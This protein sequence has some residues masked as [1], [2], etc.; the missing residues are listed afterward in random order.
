MSAERTPDIAAGRL[1]AGRHCREF[2]RPPPAA[3]AHRPSSRPTAA[4]S[5]TTRP[6]SRPARPAID[7]PL[8]IREIL[9]DNPKGAAETILSAEHPRRHVR[10]RLPDRDALR[11]GLRARSGRG[12]AG[13]DRRTAALRHRRLMRTASSRSARGARP[14]SAS[15]WSAAAR[16][17]SSCAHRLAMHGHE[18]VIYEARR[19][20]RRPQRIRH[21][22]LQDGRRLR[23]GRGRF[24]ALD[25]RHHA[26]RPARR[27]AATSRSPNSAATMTRCSSASASR[28][29]TRSASPAEDIAGVERRGRLYRRAPPGGGPRRAARRPARGGGRRRHD[30]HRHR[31]PVEAA[32]RRGRHHRLSPR[33]RADGRQ[34]ISSASWP[35]PTASRS[36]STPSRSGWS[37]TDGHVDGDRVRIHRRARRPAL[38]APARPSRFDADMVFKAIGQTFVPGG[39]QRRRRDARRSRA[40]ASRSTPSAARPCRASGPAA[41]ASPAARTSPSSPSRTASW[42]PSRSTAR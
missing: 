41:T 19:E 14:A 34:R 22:R 9:T 31:L 21:R 4:I 42:R 28:A 17:G 23:P 11:G 1:P 13:A 26:S 37:A 24:H 40:A 3:R 5:A 12:Q 15:R 36:S 6:A 20:D 8:F 30:R 33:R 29:S 16:P 18:V 27:S 2:R 35:R 7:I 25:R 39:P 10:P 32:R 38:P